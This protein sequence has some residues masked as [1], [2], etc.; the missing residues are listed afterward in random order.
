M[1]APHHHHH[2]H[3]PA[4]GFC[5]SC[6]H[7]RSMCCCHRECRKEAKELLVQ[8]TL[9]R[10]QVGTDATV[11]MNLRKMSFATPF[12]A[13]ILSTDKTVEISDNLSNLREA[14]LTTPFSAVSAAAANQ[15][16]LG[17]GTAFIGGGCCVHLS[18]EYTPSAPTTAS[19]V[20]IV[21][22]DSEGTI[23]AWYK[24]EQPGI[25]YQIKECVVTTKPGADL[26]VVVLNMTA[27]VRWCE[28]FS[29]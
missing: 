27:R 22:R 3:G 15:L 28:V 12:M 26:F 17:L 23:L 1:H 11:A 5:H 2:H 14:S 10:D 29:C 8:P 21:V 24:A 7:P 9:S 20:M 18:V 6:C 16:R 19:A 13:S 25:G 4:H